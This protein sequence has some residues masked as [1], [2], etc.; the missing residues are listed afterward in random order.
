MPARW[1][2]GASFSR[3][4]STRGS[5]WRAERDGGAKHSRILLMLK[6]IEMSDWKNKVRFEVVKEVV[7]FLLPLIFAASLGALGGVSVSAVFEAPAAVWIVLVVV[8]VTGGM[9]TGYLLHRRIRKTI[10]NL[11]R[12]PIDFDV[13]KLK[14]GYHYTTQH[15]MVY[16]KGWTLKASRSNLDRL[17]DKYLWTGRGEIDVAPVLVSQEYREIGKRSVWT[18]FDVHFGRVLSRKEVIDVALQWSLTDEEGSAVPFFSATITRPTG[19]LEFELGLPPEAGVTE[20]LCE[21][22]NGIDSAVTYETET[23]ELDKH[24]EATWTIKNP[25]LLHH[26]VVSWSMAGWGQTG[27]NKATS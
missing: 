20:V 17:T 1:R 22:T 25:K 2:S 5:G 26:Y 4:R 13:V 8:G 19:E 18:Y 23:I 3:G 10:P 11:P 15:E 9:L 14:V 6:L 16:T 12:I 24:G 21:K 27:H 7:K